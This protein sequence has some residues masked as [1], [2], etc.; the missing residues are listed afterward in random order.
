MVPV[1][2]CNVPSS[3][4]AV[5][6]PQVFYQQYL[7]YLAIR[8]KADDDEM[9]PIMGEVACVLM[10]SLPN[11]HDTLCDGCQL[12]CILIC[13]VRAWSKLSRHSWATQTKLSCCVTASCSSPAPQSSTGTWWSLQRSVITVCIRDVHHTSCVWWITDEGS[14]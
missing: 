9:L 7:Q 12:M 4:T 3:F 8:H 13:L 11:E 10:V 14:R 5:C 2:V 1:L 6:P